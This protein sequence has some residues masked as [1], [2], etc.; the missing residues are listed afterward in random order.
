M[1]VGPLWACQQACETFYFERRTGNCFFERDQPG[2]HSWPLAAGAAIP[3]LRLIVRPGKCCTVSAGCATLQHTNSCMACWLWSIPDTQTGQRV[4]GPAL[5][6]TCYPDDPLPTAAAAPGTWPDGSNG[7]GLRFKLPRSFL[8]I[9]HRC[10]AQAWGHSARR[11]GRHRLR[12]AHEHPGGRVVA[13]GCSSALGPLQLPSSVVFKHLSSIVGEQH[14]RA[15][16][17]A[18]RFCPELRVLGYPTCQDL[19]KQ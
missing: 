13:P 9:I 5:R 11:A 19:C 3:L 18:R 1:Q 2:L 10:P 14:S 15:P 4:Q 16:C 8:L 12:W 7:V 6:V 17:S